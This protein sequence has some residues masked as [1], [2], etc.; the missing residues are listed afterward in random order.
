MPRY[1]L[2]APVLPNYGEYRFEGP[3]PLTQ[4][5]A[6]AA[7]GVCSAI[8]HEAT[9]RHLQRELGVA[10]PFSRMRINML[11]GDTA[12]VLKLAE[13]LPEG[14]VLDEAQLAAQPLEFGLLTR[15]G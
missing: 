4:A 2:N 12:L 11:A 6:Y 13:R 8:G 5:K 10:V 1:L 15:I 14:L 7:E 3:L 9:A